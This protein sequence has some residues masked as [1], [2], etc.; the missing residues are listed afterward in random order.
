MSANQKLRSCA[1]MVTHPLTLQALSDNSTDQTEWRK[2][3]CSLIEKALYSG[4][5]IEVSILREILR[6]LAPDCCD[7]ITKDGLALFVQERDLFRILFQ[8]DKK[9]LLRRFLE[10]I[11]KEKKPEQFDLGT[12]LCSVLPVGS[13][14]RT[15]KD[16]RFF[17]HYLQLTQLILGSGYLVALDQMTALLLEEKPLESEEPFLR[18][19]LTLAALENQPSAFV[20]GKVRLARLYQSQYRVPECQATLDELEEMGVGELPEVLALK[21]NLGGEVQ[22]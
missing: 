20:F 9:A 5:F 12:M 8:N 11:E 15:V 1:Q 14:L 16:I 10:L 6:P 21:E 7:V 4:Q 3:M 17:K 22:L 19:Y 2:D 18:L 13:P